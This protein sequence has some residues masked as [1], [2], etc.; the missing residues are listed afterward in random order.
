MITHPKP[1]YRWSEKF[2]MWLIVSLPHQ[3]ASNGAGFPKI[4]Y[5]KGFWL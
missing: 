5:T 3:M 1:H 2:R 4:L